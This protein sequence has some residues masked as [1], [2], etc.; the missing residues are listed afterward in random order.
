MKHKLLLLYSWFVKSTLYFVPDIDFTMRFRGFMY[1][2]GMKKCGS[3]FQVSN[4]VIIKEL[5]NITV[6]NDVFIGNNSI[7][8]G[9]GEIVIE[10]EVLIGPNC[11]IISGNHSFKN[12]SYRF[13]EVV[14]KGRIIISFGSWISANCVVASGASLPKGSVLGANSF[15]NKCFHDA[16]AIYGG[17]PAKFIKTIHNYQN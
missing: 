2:L 6:G 11:T 16:G 5:E 7:I 15:L 17:N 9:S 12:G 1:G 14:I 3:N 13:G 8:M 10:S 4:N